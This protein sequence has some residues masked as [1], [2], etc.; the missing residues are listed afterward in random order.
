M[1]TTKYMLATVMVLQIIIIYLLV[2][3]PKK[4]VNQF[5][6]MINNRMVDED[7]SKRFFR[8]E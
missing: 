8:S 6:Y 7:Q 3:K 2:R 1:C 4:K 5:S